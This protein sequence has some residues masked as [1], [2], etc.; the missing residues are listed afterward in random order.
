MTLE[1]LNPGTDQVTD[2]VSQSR[3]F[4]VFDYPHPNDATLCVYA[5]PQGNP[6]IVAGLARL[7]E[8]LGDQLS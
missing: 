3:R 5:H 8:D 1:L 6:A 7:I 4:P 2:P